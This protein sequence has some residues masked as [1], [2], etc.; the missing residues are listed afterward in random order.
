MIIC[1][2]HFT[3]MLILNT[4][5][6]I[7]VLR[8]VVVLMSNIGNRIKDRRI[9]LGM[10]QDEL[11]EKMG[12]KSR[13]TIA[14]IEKGVN[15]VVQSNIVKFSEVLKTDVSYLMGWQERIEADP[16]GEANKLADWYLNLEM[17][18]ENSIMLEEFIR[19]D[20]Q[21]QAQAREFIHFLSGRN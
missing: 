16:V 9:E 3:K 2:H 14:K 19:L 17:K 20:E 5:N 1:Q 4:N 15:D 7:I 6:A 8:K 10:S 21:K 13:S 12:Y 18:E 11:A